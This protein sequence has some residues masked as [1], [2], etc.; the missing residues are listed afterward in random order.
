MKHLKTYTQKW[1]TSFASLFVI[2]LLTIA[3]EDPISEIGSE[4]ILPND[5][6]GTYV[7]DTTTLELSTVL[8]DSNITSQNNRLLFGRYVDP[9]FGSVEARPYF[10]VTS[11]DTLRGDANSI[12]DSVVLRLGY[13][14]YAGDTLQPINMTVH[15]VKEKIGKNIGGLTLNLIESLL[16]KSTYFNTSSLSYDSNPIGGLNNFKPRPQATKTRVSK[17]DSLYNTLNVKLNN[18]IGK[19]IL[20]LGKNGND[21]NFKEAF[22]GLVLIPGANDNGSILGFEPSNSP[23]YN[24]GRPNFSF[25]SSF[26]GVYYHTP[27]KKD[28]L[29]NVFP[30]SFE[31]SPNYNNRFNQIIT[32][33]TGVLAALKKPNDE[34]KAG[35][36]G[37][38]Y[39]QGSTGV[40]GRIRFPNLLNLAKDGSVAINKVE[41]ELTSQKNITNVFPTAALELVY[42]NPNNSKMPFRYGDGSLYVIPGTYSTQTNPTT[43]I[44]GYNPSKN[45]YSFDLT[46]YVNDVLKGRVKND[47]FF[48]TA[49]RDFR[50]NRLVLDRKSIKFKIYYTKLGKVQ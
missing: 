45:T 36:T 37:E 43:Q 13:N 11:F 17:Q 29:R 7:T 14:H 30:V 21:I 31:I 4:L 25:K 33:R 47:G 19:E 5:K 40:S 22:K 35:A 41:L 32:Q 9:I 50:A 18:A 6:F 28:T 3:C 23:T 16:Y 15:R 39:V 38:I 46:K 1:Q 12:I 10:E 2:A 34:I 24:D 27:N 44:T 20:S 42:A 49:A 48:I 26:L 8:L